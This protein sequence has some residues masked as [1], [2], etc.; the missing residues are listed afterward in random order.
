MYIFR[1]TYR[2]LDAGCCHKKF[3]VFFVRNSHFSYPRY[4]TTNLEGEM[5][6]IFQYF[7]SSSVAG[8]H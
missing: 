7:T 1:H 6:N 4:F 8:K 3:W 2:K 5:G